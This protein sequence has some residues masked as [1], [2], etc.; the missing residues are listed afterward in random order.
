M[1]TEKVYIK[2]KIVLSVPLC[3]YVC[4]WKINLYKHWFSPIKI[5]DVDK[6]LPFWMARGARD[7]VYFQLEVS[8][9]LFSSC[10]TVVIMIFHSGM[11]MTSVMSYRNSPFS[12]I[13]VYK[14]EVFSMLMQAK[15]LPAVN[16]NKLK[17]YSV[18]NK[19]CWRFMWLNNFCLQCNLLIQVSKRVSNNSGI[20]LCV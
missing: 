10:L 2:L 14:P 1:H 5:T 18:I 3:V 6:V 19:W 17:G 11:E 9:L 16:Q 7:L 20:T 13:I 8:F 15:K 12:Q 4:I